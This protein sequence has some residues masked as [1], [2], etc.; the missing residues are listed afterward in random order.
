MF[1]V[2]SGAGQPIDVNIITRQSRVPPESKLIDG[3][4]QRLN[5]T[6]FRAAVQDVTLRFGC[7]IERT[8]W[9]VLAA[10]VDGAE[11]IGLTCVAPPTWTGD[12]NEEGGPGGYADTVDAELLTADNLYPLCCTYCRDRIPRRSSACYLEI[13]LVWHES[14]TTTPRSPVASGHFGARLSRWIFLTMAVGNGLWPV[15]DRH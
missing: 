4:T 11:G 5:R 2:A 6:T 10:P 7:P 1:V 9:R 14:A 13:L 15:E 8:V 12:G 3:F